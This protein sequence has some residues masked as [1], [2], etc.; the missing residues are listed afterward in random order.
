MQ[1]DESEI[2][3]YIPKDVD[4]RKLKAFCLRL[5]GKKVKEICEEL[6][7]H[8]NTLGR[9]SREYWWGKVQDLYEMNLAKQFSMKLTSLQG[10]AVEALARVLDQTDPKS[11]GAQVQAIKLLME[12]GND[13]LI[14]KNPQVQITNNTLVTGG[15]DMDKLKGLSQEEQM[16]IAATGKIP[17]S[18]KLIEE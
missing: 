8:P 12:K 5:E 13:P 2:A 17:D 7:I 11:A 4:R 3:E 6:G 1:I 9:W 15:L 10:K 14:K 18:V 16:E